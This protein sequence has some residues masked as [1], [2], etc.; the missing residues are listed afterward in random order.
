MRGISTPDWPKPGVIEL[1]A[2]VDSGP[3][4]ATA[5]DAD[6]DHRACVDFLTRTDIEM[7]IPA[8]SVAEI[9]YFL[10]QRHGADAEA[11]FVSGLADFRVVAPDPEDW[12]QIGALVRTYAD[13]PLGATD[14]SVAVLADRL[15]TRRI[16]TLD[17]RHF[18][19]I[20]NSE[21]RAFELYP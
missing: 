14:A 13:L 12:P 9:C 21:G 20:R 1:L 5:N 11:T 3:L 2:I 7:V 6:P 16:V 17:R 18:S 10:G 4:L 19:I 15:R 8:L